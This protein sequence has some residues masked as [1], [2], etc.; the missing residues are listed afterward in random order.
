MSSVPEMSD[1][2]FYNDV[3]A[4]V[5]IK[6]YREKEYTVIPIIALVEGVRFGANQSNPELCLAEHFGESI[7]SW[8]LIPVTDGHPKVDGNFVSA[9]SLELQ[10][11]WAI[12]FT[13]GA[14]LEDSK[15]KINVWLENARAAQIPNVQVFLDAANNNEMFEVSVGFFSKVIPQAGVYEGNKYS[16]IVTNVVPDHLALLANATGACSIADGC[17]GPRVFTLSNVKECSC[18]TEDQTSSPT[19]SSMISP[20]NGGSPGDSLVEISLNDYQIASGLLNSSVRDLLSASLKDKFSQAYLIDYSSGPESI[21]V[22]DVWNDEAG[23]YTVYG[24]RFNIDQEGLVELVGDEF[25]VRIVSYLKTMTNKEHDMSGVTDA[26]D[27]RNKTSNAS[28]SASEPVVTNSAVEVPEDALLATYT[29]GRKTLSMDDAL[30][31]LSEADRAHLNAALDAYTQAHTDAIEEIVA[32]DFN[33]LPQVFLKSQP[34][35]VVQEILTT[36]RAKVTAASEKQA[37]V[38]PASDSNVRQIADYSGKA[39]AAPHVLEDMDASM[40]LPTVFEVGK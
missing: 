11:E 22:F 35:E 26:G 6:T 28:A 4:P 21:A 24:Q 40:P 31:T 33:V 5:E 1:L 20:P 12:G 34:F 27:D 29:E 15:L 13:E 17:G 18:G 3:N 38:V 36:L 30:K 32:S 23:T 37:Q 25:K 14:R 10:E 39:P 8:N 19:T 9:R 7:V 16:G 2:R